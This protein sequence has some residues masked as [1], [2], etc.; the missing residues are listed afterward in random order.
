[1]QSEEALSAELT[2]VFAFNRIL[3]RL[4]HAANLKSDVSQALLLIL[5]LLIEYGGFERVEAF[6]Y[7]EAT[8]TMHGA[9]AMDDAGFAQKL[10][11]VSTALHDVIGSSAAH[12]ERDI[13]PYILYNPSFD[14]GDPDRLNVV[15]EY[16]AA[17]LM[18]SIAGEVLGCLR[19]QNNVTNRTILEAQIAELI[20]F[21][22]QAS[23]VL[24]HATVRADHDTNIRRLMRMLD[25]APSMADIGE[26]PDSIYRTVRD[27][28]F[29]TCSFDRVCFFEVKGDT[30]YATWGTDEE[31]N[32]RDE[33]GMQFQV[34]SDGRYFLPYS[35]NGNRFVIDTIRAI[36]PDGTV[37]NDI[38]HAYVPLWSGAELIGIVGMDN[39]LSMRGITPAMMAPALAISDQA[40]I[41]L[42][43][44]SLLGHQ[45]MIVREQRRLME[46]AVAVT[47]HVDPDAIFKMIR[48]AIFETGVV[49][50]VGV[51]IVEGE[52]AYGT[53]GTGPDGRA[54]DEHD[55]FF[56]I[57]GLK[58]IYDACLAGKTPYVIDHSR[59]GRIDDIETDYNVPY[60]LIP[61]RAGNEM[62][63]LVTVD[64][65]LTLRT[66][67]P[68][69]IEMILPLVQLAAVAIQNSRLMMAAEQE[70]E[71]RRVAEELLLA[72]AKE[73]T[74]A[75]DQ[76]I[77][78]A[79]VKSE[80]LANM[81]HE[82]R[83]P[84]NGII[85][86][87]SILLQSRLTAE[88]QE[89]AKS[90]QRSAEA[91]LTIIDD[92]LDISRLEANMLKIHAH[93]FNRRDCLED[94]AEMMSAQSHEKTV[95]LNCYVPVH[96]PEWLVGDSNRIRQMVL[97]LMGNALKF[98]SS[99]EVN[100]EATCLVDSDTEAQIRIS[101]LDTG[102]GIPEEHLDAVFN[103]FT[104]VDSSSTRK[105]GG[106]GLGLTIT[107][108]LAELMGG[109]VGLQSS[110]GSGSTFW[111]DL[112]LR[113]QI[114]P[115]SLLGVSKDVDE[116]RMIILSSNRTNLGVLS[117]YATAW[118]CDVLT[119]E[120]AGRATTYLD[121][122]PELRPFHIL[123]IDAEIED[124]PFSQ[125][126]QD[127]RK[128]PPCAESS[129]ILLVPHLG[130]A[131]TD[132]DR[133]SEF[134]STLA[135]PI[136]LSQFRTLLMQAVTGA[137][138]ELDPDRPREAEVVSLGLKVLL[139][140]DNM[141]NA[142]VASRRL[143]DWQCHVTVAENGVEVLKAMEMERF[144]VVLMD[145]SMPIM[146]GLQATRE[147]RQREKGEDSRIPII[148]ITAYAL[149][150]DRE[151]CLESG[152]DDY[153]AK[154]IK[155]SELLEKLRYWCPRH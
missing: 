29:D 89:Y 28:I 136:R 17:T 91:L 82:I 124:S 149:K 34:R 62:I 102:V 68:E 103:S 155:F 119:F 118:G 144:D 79:K 69:D 142:F 105:Y 77:S 143:E 130:A 94:V 38:P 93:P 20:P 36:L 113:K 135:K 31:G 132:S 127:L 107:K 55:Y 57:D 11:G 5:K 19:I 13:R 104:Q 16:S 51:F 25:V 152:M 76:A 95:S 63:G 42:Q 151:R 108:Q 141:V 65:L 147:I 56:R 98:T 75:R 22:E 47:A 138:G 120:S 85:G 46:I 32:I 128:R 43:K 39:L 58:E 122:Q 7:E 33:H 109:K 148:A 72:Q 92:I 45:E 61:M 114:P 60:G 153:L 37:V 3:V 21:A 54:R 78:A 140:E 35:Q 48:D 2:R 44:S 52:D 80:F 87:T 9:W 112:P 99:G 4:A 133:H 100:L 81:S 59:K 15:Q 64:M 86:L 125:V 150:G 49:D 90:V 129:A 24:S 41:A 121:S 117:A 131:S 110:V 26:N 101:V 96:F 74:I 8:Q 115:K 137:K 1:M 134:A 139:A 18:L 106:T 6:L 40:A 53:W 123:M 14:D 30:A 23:L 10:T 50:R 83:T 111:I 145:I 73:L 84:M 27:A 88:Q 97:N 116:K 126:L 146:D 71:R 154:P 70:I 66:L 67:Q 12:I